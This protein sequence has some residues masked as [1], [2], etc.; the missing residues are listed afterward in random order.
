M[1]ID[2]LNFKTTLGYVVQQRDKI[3]DTDYTGLIIQL[4]DD[5]A[6][7]SLNSFFLQF[8]YLCT[9]NISKA[10]KGLR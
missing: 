10:K 5:L 1:E 6:L 9:L 4:A 2:T 7:P 3:F 8:G